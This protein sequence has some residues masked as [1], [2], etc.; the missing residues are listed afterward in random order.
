TSASPLSVRE[1]LDF[2]RVLHERGLRVDSVVLNRVLPPFPPPPPPEAVRA[3]LAGQVDPDVLEDMLQ[4]V[5]AV[6]AGLRVQGEQSVAAGQALTQAYPRLP[7]WLLPLRDPAPTS[8]ADLA[9]LV[10]QFVRWAGR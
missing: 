5:L 7:L 10:A 1:A 2:L 6:Y 8:V 3:A 9:E 4:R